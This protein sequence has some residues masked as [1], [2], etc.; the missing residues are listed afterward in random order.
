M[1]PVALTIAL[2]GGVY[3]LFAAGRL[4][5]AGP[6][7]DPA[8]AAV[9][10]DVDD[11]HRDAPSLGDPAMF[12]RDR[13]LDVRK[14][15]TASGVFVAVVLVSALGIAPIAATAFAGAVALVLLRVIAVD[16]AYRGLKPE[17][18]LLIAGMVVVG[19]SL[20]VTGLASTLTD[21][22]IEWIRPLGPLAA[23]AILYGATLFLTEILSNAAVAVLMTPVAVALAESL[24]VSPRPFLIGVMMAGSAAFATPF[25]YQTNVLVFQIGKYRYMDFVRIGVPLNLLTWMVGVGAIA[26][27]FPF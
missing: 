17:V 7:G 2:A 6:E 11:H 9:A 15:L 25:G 18:L 3:L 4:L 23:L 8:P 26:L 1:T 22:L 12:A 24:G 16:D 20:E 14:A 27:F 10:A 19:L 21:A 13:P 5:S